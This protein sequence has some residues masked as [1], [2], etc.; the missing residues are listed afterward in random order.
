LNVTDNTLHK[1]PYRN[2]LLPTFCKDGNTFFNIECDR[3]LAVSNIIINSK[4]AKKVNLNK[5]VGNEWIH[6]SLVINMLS[7]QDKHAFLMGEGNE[8]LVIRLGNQ[9]WDTTERALMIQIKNLTAYSELKNLGYKKSVLRHIIQHR[10]VNIIGLVK[11]LKSSSRKKNILTAIRLF[12]YFY[13]YRIFW[14]Q[15]LPILLF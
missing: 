7:S 12:K 10:L 3:V 1:N 11:K 6:I 4:E 14:I 5:Y 8:T 2:V 15:Y 9:R 13:C